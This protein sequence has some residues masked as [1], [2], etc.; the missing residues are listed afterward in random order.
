MI[1]SAEEFITLRC[2]EE[3]ELYTRAACDPAPEEVWLDVINHYP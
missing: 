1:E 3:P 2:S